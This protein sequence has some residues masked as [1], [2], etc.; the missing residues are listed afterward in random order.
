MND[1]SKNYK[2]YLKYS[3]LLNNEIFNNKKYLRIMIGKNKEFI[4]TYL[5]TIGIYDK[6]IKRCIINATINCN[7]TEDFT[8]SFDKLMNIYQIFETLFF[9][10]LYIPYYEKFINKENIDISC[11]NLFG[12]NNIQNCHIIAIY[13]LYIKTLDK[14]DNMKDNMKDKLDNM[15]DNMKDDMNDDINSE[16][17]YDINKIKDEDNE[18]DEEDIEIIENI[19]EHVISKYLPDNKTNNYLIFSIVGFI[20]LFIILFIVL[21]IL[22][23]KYH[24]SKNQ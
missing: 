10:E 24:K 21:I 7:I 13:Q 17:Y 18:E 16:E 9:K 2:K 11:N 15:N 19:E 22:A 3:H 6:L 4:N 23:V 5:K 14:L 8:D 1:I 20:V 12:L